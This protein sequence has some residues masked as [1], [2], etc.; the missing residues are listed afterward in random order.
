MPKKAMQLEKPDE[1]IN[2]LAMKD[3]KR[4]LR[5]YPAKV[6]RL[7]EGKSGTERIAIMTAEMEKALY[8]FGAGPR[9]ELRKLHAA[10]K[11]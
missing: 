6:A 4:R 7:I 9:A 1:V 2:E 8:G 3:V 10:G 5:T 11:I